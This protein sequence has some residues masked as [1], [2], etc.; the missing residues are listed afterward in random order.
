M[1]I[2]LKDSFLSIVQKPGDTDLLTV[3][4]RIKGD[5]EQLF[6]DAEV[7][8]DAGTDYKFRARVPRE[9]VAKALFDC[10]MNL[11]APNFKA[12]IKNKKRHDAYMRVWSAMYREQEDTHAAPSSVAP[13]SSA[14]SPE[15]VIP[16]NL[17]SPMS[18]E[19]QVSKMTTAQVA[20]IV[21]GVFFVGALLFL[22]IYASNDDIHAQ[23]SPLQTGAPVESPY[24]QTGPAEPQSALE[25]AKP[26]LDNLPIDPNVVES[27]AQ[28]ERA[29]FASQ[30]PGVNYSAYAVLAKQS[31]VSDGVICESLDYNGFCSGN[32][33]VIL[34]K[35]DMPEDK[36]LEF[37]DMRGKSGCFTVQADSYRTVYIVNFHSGMCRT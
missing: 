18:Q 7:I 21:L 8:A 2:F 19:R 15:H 32:A 35:S 9:A 6:P 33:K 31:A 36:A 5:I 34:H 14:G 11:D 24:G 23:S 16:T 29:L 25:P 27:V 4:A 37:Y 30:S 22:G 20:F 10:V 26:P 1:W 12:S 17:P 3:R 13:A 28:L